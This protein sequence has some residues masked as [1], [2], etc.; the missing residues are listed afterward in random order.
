VR[1]SLRMLR[2][3]PGFTAIAIL[4]MALGIGAT[5]A[6]FSVVDATLLQPLPYSHPDRLISIQADLRFYC[7]ILKRR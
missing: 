1:F 3:S 7:R 5:S 2:K 6:I 4:T